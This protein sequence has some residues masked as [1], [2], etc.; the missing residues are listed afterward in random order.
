MVTVVDAKEFL[1]DFSTAESLTDRAWEATLEDD[2][3][4]VDLLVEQVEFCD[5]LVVN[6]ISEISEEEKKTLR[7]ILK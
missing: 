6:K 5:V 7:A 2:R 4:I 3:T 1:R